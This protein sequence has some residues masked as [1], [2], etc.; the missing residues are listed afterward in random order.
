[1]KADLTV[2]RI[3]THPGDILRHELEVRGVSA[4]QLALAL[5]VP[6]GRIVEIL[7]RKRGISADTALRLARYI[8]TSAQFWMNLQAQYDL[9][10]VQE[11][12]GRLIEAR[13]QP[14]DSEHAL[15]R[16]RTLRS[17]APKSRKRHAAG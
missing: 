7:N 4:N 1:M 2:H 14:A 17:T 15:K 9:S 16:S 3:R 12:S 8:G 13:V 5:G 10:V 11:Q 6:S